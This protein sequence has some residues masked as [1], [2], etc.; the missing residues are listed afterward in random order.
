VKE[1]SI[2]VAAIIHD[3]VEDNH[4]WNIERVRLEFG[5]QV[6]LLVDYLTKPSKRKNLSEEKRLKI[7]HD[8][9]EFAPREF[10]I[11]KLVDRLHNLLTLWSSSPDKIARKIK[12]TREHYLPYAEKHIIIIHELEAALKDLE[13][14]FPQ[15]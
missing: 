4:F 9:F 2:I 7:Y 13:E 12:E 11:I 15:Q 6:A 1:P 10:F 8:R 3:I 5:D 14:K